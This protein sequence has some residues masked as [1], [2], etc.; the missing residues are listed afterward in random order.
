[1]KTSEEQAIAFKRYIIPKLV[2]G[3]WSQAMANFDFPASL[4]FHVL[5]EMMMPWKASEQSVEV[6][7]AAEVTFGS[8]QG[9]YLNGVG[10]PCV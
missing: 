7:Y 5:G 1:M 8:I 2:T 9:A 3:F 4:R 10:F 6:L